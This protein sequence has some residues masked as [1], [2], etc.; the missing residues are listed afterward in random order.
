MQSSSDTQSIAVGNGIVE[1]NGWGGDQVRPPSVVRSVRPSRLPAP[2]Y[3]TASQTVVL[4]QLT[5]LTS[6]T[7]GRLWVVQ[8]RP[9]SLVAATTPVLPVTT[10]IARDAHDTA[11]KKPPGSSAGRMRQLWPPFVVPYTT[12]A[13]PLRLPAS[14]HRVADQH[15]RA[16]R[17]NTSGGEGSTVQLAPAS[18][19]TMTLG[20]FTAKQVRTDGQLTALS[21]PNC[22]A[23][24]GPAA[25]AVR[26][27]PR[28]T[29][30]VA[31]MRTAIAARRNDRTA[32]VVMASLRDAVSS[33]TASPTIA[34]YRE[35]ARID[36]VRHSRTSARPAAS[37]RPAA[38]Q[39]STPSMTSVASSPSS[40][41]A[42][43]AKDEL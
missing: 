7:C 28:P 9:S 10:H 6:D 3:A 5:P 19:V 24:E 17:S 1:G 2:E 20:P 25:F 35:L 23:G 32:D 21:V 41:K 26:A 40:R 12:P 15:D 31:P 30:R 18:V 14:T 39:P 37:G 8:V 29:T 16:S 11:R 13:S 36:R 42:R 33:E 43:A 34:T 4:T 22:R 38:H 27:G